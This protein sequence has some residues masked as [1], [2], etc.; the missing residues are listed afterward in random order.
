HLHPTSPETS[1]P[2]R[3]AVE[4]ALALCEV[5]R[6][7]ELDRLRI[8]EAA[9]CDDALLDLSKNHSRRFCSTLC[10]NRTNVAAYRARQAQ[11]RQHVPGESHHEA[12]TADA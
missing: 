11:A 2:Q 9:D 5:I 7:G 3:M 12:T 10:L 6:S 1:L 8:C 4:A